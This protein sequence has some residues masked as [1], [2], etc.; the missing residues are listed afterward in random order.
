MYK[1]P[2]TTLCVLALRLTFRGYQK[3]LWTTFKIS[4]ILETQ[5]WLTVSWRCPF[6]GSATIFFSSEYYHQSSWFLLYSDGEY[7]SSE[8]E[9]MTSTGVLCSG[10]DC[11]LLCY[12]CW[13]EMVFICRTSVEEGRPFLYKGWRPRPLFNMFFRTMLFFLLVS[14]RE[15]R[16]FLAVQETGILYFTCV[17]VLGPFWFCWYCATVCSSGQRLSLFFLCQRMTFIIVVALE[18]LVDLPGARETCSL[19]SALVCALLSCLT[20]RYEFSSY[21]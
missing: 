8:C 3:A 18:C 12:S 1:Q 6:K 11:H 21:F 10:R 5:Q 2:N 4:R 15:W 20:A 14:A 7:V 13:N 19:V 17:T 9:T 16:P